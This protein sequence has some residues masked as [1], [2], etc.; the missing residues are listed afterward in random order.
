MHS[1]KQKQWTETDKEKCSYQKHT[2]MQ[3]KTRDKKTQDKELAKKRP[4]NNISSHLTY[5]LSTKKANVWMGSDC[6]LFNFT[7]A[8]RT[9]WT[10]SMTLLKITTMRSALHQHPLRPSLSTALSHCYK[11]KLP[12]S[13]AKKDDL[14][15]LCR[16]RMIPDEHHAFY[17][18]LPTASD[19]QDHLEEPDFS[20][21][22]DDTD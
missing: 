11:S 16:S 5:R 6:E 3:N 20:N 12:V 10:L 18:T 9:S 2:N 19:K 21:S 15:F 4:T 22:G 7:R 14:F 1:E 17:H 13:K 8:R